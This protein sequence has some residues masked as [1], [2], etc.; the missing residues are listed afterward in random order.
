M[1]DSDFLTLDDEPDESGYRSKPKL[2][3]LATHLKYHADNLQRA[4]HTPAEIRQFLRGYAVCFLDI[5]PSKFDEVPDDATV[6][7]RHRTKCELPKG[8][9]RSCS[10]RKGTGKRF[11][12]NIHDPA[13]GKQTYI[14]TFDS[15]E[16]ASAA[17]KAKHVEFHGEDSPY[18]DEVLI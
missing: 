13:A 3:E 16:E 5:N 10:G 4:G 9:S 8:V 7:T 2:R 6:A 11:V 18:F 12:A 17:Y 1:T 15:P 14:G